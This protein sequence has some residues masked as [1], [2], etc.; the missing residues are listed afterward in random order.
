MPAKHERSSR[1]LFEARRLRL[2][3][4]TIILL[5]LIGLLFVAAAMEGLLLAFKASGRS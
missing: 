3:A 2:R 1:W 4:S 5:S